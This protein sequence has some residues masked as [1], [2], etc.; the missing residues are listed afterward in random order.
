MTIQGMFRPGMRVYIMPL[1][2]GLLLV[3]SAFLP[4]V[5]VGDVPEGIAC[6]AVTGH[7]SPHGKAPRPP[8][9]G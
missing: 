1:V 2:A 5:H 3:L 7:S 6:G 9:G 4:W 8:K